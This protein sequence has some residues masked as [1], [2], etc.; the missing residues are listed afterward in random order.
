MRIFPTAV[1]KQYVTTVIVGGDEV[2]T[3]RL[4][5]DLPENH[6]VPAEAAAAVVHV[7]ETSAAP[8]EAGILGVLLSANE[9]FP[10]AQEATALAAELA[11][12]HRA[13][14]DAASLVAYVQEA[15]PAPAETVAALIAVLTEVS[16]AAVEDVTGTEARAQV[17]ETSPAPSAQVSA[18]AAVAESAPPATHVTTVAVVV[19]EVLAAVSEDVTGTQAQAQVNET[20]PAAAATTTLAAAV[21]ESHKVSD[22]VAY[23]KADGYTWPGTVVSSSGYTGPS[24]AADKDLG[25]AARLQASSSGIGNLTSNTVNGTLVLSAAG[26]ALTDLTIVSVILEVGTNTFNGS[27]LSGQAVNMPLE[28]SLNDGASWTTLATITNTAEGGQLR[29]ADL[30]A[31]IAGDWTKV[32][33]F[34]FRA[35]GS[36]TSGVGTVVIAGVQTFDLAYA[37]LHVVAEGTYV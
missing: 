13:G 23:A 9:T 30:T 19:A 1:R 35:N 25:S 16:P 34:R 32:D 18:V 26:P 10:V 27:S 29:T 12:M 36:V 4:M 3:E 31:T 33:Q 24:F 15:H 22:D 21:A 17:N 20:A 2:T 14:F 5:Y 28:Y 37:R 8:V 11:E 6:P 7:N